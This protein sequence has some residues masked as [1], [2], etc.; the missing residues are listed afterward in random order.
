MTELSPYQLF[1]ND[2]GPATEVPPLPEPKEL[3]GPKPIAC[4]QCN[5]PWGDDI[6]CDWHGPVRGRWLCDECFTAERGAGMPGEVAAAIHKE[7][8]DERIVG[9]QLSIVDGAIRNLAEI[10]WIEANDAAGTFRSVDLNLSPKD[11]RPIFLVLREVL[12]RKLQQQQAHP[13]YERLKDFLKANPPET[14][15]EP[16]TAIE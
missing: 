4:Q 7:F 2:T 15:E 14:Q 13:V 9:Q 10:K 1:L 11:S 5:R 6:F 3:A 16:G 8:M 12:K